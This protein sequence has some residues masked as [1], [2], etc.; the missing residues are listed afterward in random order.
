MNVWTTRQDWRQQVLT[1]PE[2]FWDIVRDNALN[3]AA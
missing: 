1:A 3:P 2:V